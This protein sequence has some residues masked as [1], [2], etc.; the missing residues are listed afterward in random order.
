MRETDPDVN[1][2]IVAAR[3]GDR[4]AQDALF[5]RYRNYLALLASMSLPR[6]L[7]AKFG[8]SDVVQDVFAKAH[9]AIG[10][11]RGATEEEMASW[12]RQ[13]LANELGMAHRRFV[14]NQAR[15]VGR[16]RSLDEMVEASSQ[17]LGRMPAARGT[18]PSRGAQRR[19]AGAI[20][21]DA[22]AQLKDDDREVIVLRSLEEREWS[23]VARRMDR[24]VE[25]VRALWARAC[26]RL[27][28]V[29]EAKRWSGP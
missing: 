7:R 23:E 4:E 29:V 15:Q 21:A 17:A 5:G 28:A 11:F 26:G 2:L 9:Q 3:R 16:E 18:S 1:D 27:G 13:I 10:G 19:E 22:L 25:S 6:A 14:G 12:L 24:S 20:V 8:A